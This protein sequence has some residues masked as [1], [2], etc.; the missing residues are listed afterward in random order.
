MSIKLA[1]LLH[2]QIAPGPGRTGKR[3]ATLVYLGPHLI[4][5]QFVI[6]KVSFQLESSHK[7]THTHTHTG[8]RHLVWLLNWH[9]ILRL[10]AN[11]VANT[12][13]LK[14][15]SVRFRPHQ[16]PWLTLR[17]SLAVYKGHFVWTTLRVMPRGE[18]RLAK[19]KKKRKMMEKSKNCFKTDGLNCA[20]SSIKVQMNVKVRAAARVVYHLGT[21]DTLLRSLTRFIYK[22]RVCK[23]REVFLFTFLPS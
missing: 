23:L 3:V 20:V 9:E 7:L 2:F 4:K 12:K 5:V 17:E 8:E 18:T 21:L 15:A 11:C 19:K 10:E 22:T 1:F 16:W 6:A 14:R 13:W